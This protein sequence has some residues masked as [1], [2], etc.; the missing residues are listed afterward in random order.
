MKF[1]D[2][3]QALGI[4]YPDPKTCCKGRCEGTGLIPVRAENANEEFRRR[5]EVAEKEHPAED[6]WHFIVCPECEGSGK[7]APVRRG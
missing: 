4:P 7:S 5:W 3:Y 1:T 6:G 2:R